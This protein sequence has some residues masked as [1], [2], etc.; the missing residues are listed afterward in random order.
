VKKIVIVF[1]LL[2][3]SANIAYS[4]DRHRILANA[5]LLSEQ[6]EEIRMV[7]Y[8]DK[9][10]RAMPQVKRKNGWEYITDQSARQMSKN[11]TDVEEYYGIHEYIMHLGIVPSWMR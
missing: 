10:T 7:V 9:K 2:L 4:E 11:N 3:V 1:M 8:K 6:G 5:I